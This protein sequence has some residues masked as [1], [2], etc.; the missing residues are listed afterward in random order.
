MNTLRDKKILVTGGAGFLGGYVVDVLVGR[1]VPL[2]N[3]YVPRSKLYD[4]RNYQDC[5][6]VTGGEGNAVDIVIHLAA[7]V[8]GIGYNQENPAKLF[9]DNAVMGI[10]MLEASM[11]AGVEKYVTIGTVCA[12]PMYPLVIPFR[13]EDIWDGYPEP[14][15]APYGMA[16]RMLAVQTQAYRKQYNMN[17]IYLLVANLYGPGDNF[18]LRSSHVI[19]AIMRKMLEAKRDGLKYVTLWG[20]GTPTRDFLYVKDAARGI[21]DAVLSYDSG[22]PLNIGTGIETSIKTLAIIIKQVVEY[23]GDIFWDI[24]KPGGQ[25]RRVLDI[26]N[27]MAVMGYSPCIDLQF[28]IEQ[29]YASVKETYEM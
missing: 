19:P 16:K 15:N 20:D 10:H 17:A 24:E 11:R 3:I 22:E 21:V 4:L 1:G 6:L 12:Y 18:N 7:N 9:Y 14:T 27:A 23:D 2:N 13:E 28:G 5:Y 29:L 25:P 8:G 26:S